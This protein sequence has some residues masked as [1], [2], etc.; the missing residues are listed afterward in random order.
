MSISNGRSRSVDSPA[1]AV[2]VKPGKFY[3]GLSPCAFRGVFVPLNP[4]AVG[5]KTLVILKRHG[6][7]QDLQVQPS[8][9]TA[10]QGVPM[11]VVYCPAFP[12]VDL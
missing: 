2:R 6:A 11:V 4:V 7:L 12:V 1:R 3:L 9:P 10:I 8:A 5:A